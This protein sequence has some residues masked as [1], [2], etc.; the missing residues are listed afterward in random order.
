MRYRLAEFELDTQ[1]E[2]LIGPAGVV[3][4]RPQAYRLLRYLV[5]RRPALVSRDELMDAL[6]GH[7]A[8]SPNVIPQTV[9]ELRQALGDDPQQPRFIETRH[10]RGYVLIAAVETLPEIAP[11]VAG[12]TAASAPVASAAPRS[13]PQPARAGLPV[14]WLAL[15]ALAL[16]TLGWVAL[17]PARM[18]EAVVTQIAATRFALRLKSAP[19]A[20][21]GYL[22]LLARCS[23]DWVLYAPAAAASRSAWSLTVEPD[24]GWRLHDA[25]GQERSSGALPQADVPSQAQALLRALEAPSGRSGLAR[26]PPGWPAGLD[27]RQA[28]VDAA[29]AAG[30]ERHGDALSAY[31]SAAAASSAPGWPVL[32]HAEA[33]ARSG[34]WGVASEHLSSLHG[35]ADRALALRAEILRAQLRARPAE[36]LAAQ[37]AY[38]L[39][40]P[41]AIDAR[42]ETLDLQLA[43]AQWPAAADSLEAL[44]AELGEDSAALAWRRALWLGAMQPSDAP[45]AFEWAIRRAHETGDEASRR[46]ARLALAGWHLR[47]SQ[48]AATGVAIEGLAADDPEALGLRAQLAVEQGE[49]AIARGHFEAADTIWRARGRHGESRRARLGMVEL[50]L[51]AGEHADAGMRAEALRAESRRD[52][53]AR[54]DVELLQ[55]LGRAQTGLGQLEPAREHLQRAIDL[56][57]EL[58][59]A[60]LEAGARYHLGNLHAHER[61]LHEAE[62]AYRL[63]AEVF[64]S[65]RDHRGEALAL[66]NLALMAERAGRRQDARDAYREAL[67]RLQEL[68]IPREIGRVTFNLGVS[69]R[70]LGALAQA[71]KHFDAAAAALAQAGA[72]DIRVMVSAARADLAALQ[73]DPEGARK[74][75]EA[76]ASWRTEATWLPQSAWL[77][78]M[79]RLEEL[80]GQRNRAREALRD[81]L[82]IRT[83]A[84]VRVAILDVELR[85]LRLDLAPGAAATQARLAVE[86]VESELLRLGEA[87]YALGA[88]LAAVEA[89]WIA[90]DIEAARTR[91]QELRVPIQSRGT[92]AQQLH[93]EWLQALVGEDRLRSGRLKALV[94]AAEADG[95]HLLARLA[96][97]ELLAPGSPERAA[98]DRDLAG[99]GLAG[100]AR[101]PAAAF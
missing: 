27:G 72:S 46:R 65:L 73:G 81:A 33:L 97:R 37:T 76:V 22:G 14:G 2:L 79:A 61:R 68:G 18:P 75:L 87:G 4:L 36:L 55:A 7:H 82:A 71:A 11:A 98:S 59:D 52:G 100:A 70:D 67:A 80:A 47:R 31:A 25:Q 64:R 32:L 48:L 84:A 51:R 39:L 86:A 63:A 96:R 42:L 74:A 44:G 8:L 57:R 101:I 49:L 53:D 17:R 69:E 35:A 91:V 56:A 6:W 24:G 94:Q 23:G 85:L 12:A 1:R 26:D 99:D 19:P 13:G 34:N 60:A 90:G 43:Q 95:F 16:V 9:S 45:A 88:S 83:P 15:A 89:A 28:L 66:A 62:Q 40:L 50:A 21:A 54:L 20:L 10:R 3:G 78:A 5:E 93:L 29:L 41:E 38:T 77:T 58:G 30:E 92:R